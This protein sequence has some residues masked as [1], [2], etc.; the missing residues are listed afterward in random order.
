VE[1]TVRDKKGAD[2]TCDVV[3]HMQPE[4]ICRSVEK[5]FRAVRVTFEEN[6]LAQRSAKEQ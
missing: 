3:P 4:N 2:G 1:Q 6:C 5:A